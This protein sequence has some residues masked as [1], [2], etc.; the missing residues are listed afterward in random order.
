MLDILYSLWKFK[1]NIYYVSFVAV[2]N[3]SHVIDKSVRERWVVLAFY[4][5]YDFT[6]K[7]KISIDRCDGT[8]QILYRSHCILYII[9]TI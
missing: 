3:K 9:P 6:L 7:I 5:S 8:K 4:Q 1:E 2:E